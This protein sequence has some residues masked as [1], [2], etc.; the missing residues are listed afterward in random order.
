M[1][2]KFA[3]PSLQVFSAQIDALA[4]DITDMRQALSK[5]SDAITTLALVE[6]RQVHAHNA[7]ERAFA[8]LDRLEI[9]LSNVERDQNMR[10]SQQDM[11]TKWV[12]RAVVFLVT[13]AV[14]FLAR[15]TGL[16]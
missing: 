9:R 15:K 3:E 10:L 7:M 14:M 16:M 5:L 2:A 13:A 1:D 4:E 8:A 12:D 6:E 11:T